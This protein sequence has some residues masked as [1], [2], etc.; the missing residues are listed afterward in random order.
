M[1]AVYKYL[2]TSTKID[3][4]IELHYDE[5]QLLVNFEIRSELTEEQHVWLLKRIPRELFE[6]EKLIEQKTGICISQIE[7]IITFEMFWNKYNEKTLSNKKR[8]FAKWKKMSTLEQRK[9]YQ[10]INKYINMLPNGV[11]KKYAENY[12]DSEIWNN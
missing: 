5:N 6:L 8:T 12:L 2:F 1:K 9:A 3:G 4:E 7:E 10:F 11:R